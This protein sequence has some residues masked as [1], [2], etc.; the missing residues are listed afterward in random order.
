MSSILIHFGLDMGGAVTFA[1]LVGKC[2]HKHRW[3]P[4]IF[5]ILSAIIMAIVTVRIVG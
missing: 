5:Q 3:S 1:C 2:N 4:W